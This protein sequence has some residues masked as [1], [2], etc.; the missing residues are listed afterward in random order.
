MKSKFYN[1]NSRIVNDLNERKPQFSFLKVNDE[2]YNNLNRKLSE[3]IRQGLNGMN[4]R[5]S[6]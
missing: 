3:S 5:I 4:N 6:E 1:M 2:Y